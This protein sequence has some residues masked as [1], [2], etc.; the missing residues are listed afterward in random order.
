MNAASTAQ[1]DNMRIIASK[2]RTATGAETGHSRY[3]HAHVPARKAACQ[4]FATGVPE[5]INP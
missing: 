1:M 3:A 2:S 4:R 5:Q